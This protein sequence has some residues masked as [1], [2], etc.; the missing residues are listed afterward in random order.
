MHV[1]FEAPCP[2]GHQASWSA[3]CPVSLGDAPIVSYNIR[4]PSCALE[5]S[6]LIHDQG[7]VKVGTQ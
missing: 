6:R 4:C 3:S 2:N 1:A 7:H 5:A